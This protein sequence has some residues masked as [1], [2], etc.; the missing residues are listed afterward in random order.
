MQNLKKTPMYYRGE[1]ILFGGAAGAAAALL[2]LLVHHV[3]EW[4]GLAKPFYTN[5]TSYL[6]HGHFKMKGLTGFF[7][8]ELGDMAIGAFLGALISFVLRHSRPR[9]HWWLGA[10]LG[11]GIWFAS[12]A[13]GNLAKIIKAGQTDPW[14]L[15]AHLL[16]MVA[17][18]LSIVL[19]SRIWPAY[20]E[21]IE[22]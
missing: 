13:F 4:T 5:I 16:A 15:F 1:L 21:R 14:S 11:F 12:L 18:G 19:A 3:F 17:F 7:F 2:K 6:V 20:R 10:G 9:Y 8:G 22:E